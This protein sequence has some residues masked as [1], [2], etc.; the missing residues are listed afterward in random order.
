MSTDREL[1]E[2]DDRL[3]AKR[4]QLSAQARTVGTY[5]DALWLPTSTLFLAFIS[6]LHD[7][8]MQSTNN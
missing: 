5:S 3:V 2:T 8:N 7:G 1:R 4:S 6:G